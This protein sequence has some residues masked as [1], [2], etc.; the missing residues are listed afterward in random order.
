MPPAL[1]S[2]KFWCNNCREK[3]HIFVT[4]SVPFLC[5]AF[6]WQSLLTSM[7]LN[8]LFFCI[9]QYWVATM[10]QEFV[11]VRSLPLSLSRCIR[12]R[13]HYLSM[14]HIDLPASN[15]GSANAQIIT[16]QSNYPT[17][18]EAN[19]PVDLSTW[20]FA[21]DASSAQCASVTGGTI[22]ALARS[23]RVTKVPES[24][25]DAINYL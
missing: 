1:H 24:D 10:M 17:A 3:L 25:A 11:H 7:N 18:Q 2:L 13:V 6:S 14:K 8:N 21:R 20:I 5:S 23:V 4:V 16:K 19:K 12:L 22:K 15:N 9:S